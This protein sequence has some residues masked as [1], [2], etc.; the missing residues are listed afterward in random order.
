[1]KITSQKMIDMLSR[2]A[3]CKYEKGYTELKYNQ[4]NIQ[5]ERWLI[6]RFFPIVSVS[7]RNTIVVV[8]ILVGVVRAPN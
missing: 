8:E 6:I 4:C 1:M 7:P 2:P 3:K 5:R